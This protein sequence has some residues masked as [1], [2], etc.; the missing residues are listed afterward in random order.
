MQEWYKTYPDVIPEGGRGM[1]GEAG[2]ALN[3]S[4]HDIPPVKL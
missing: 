4:L 3:P 1:V 2:G